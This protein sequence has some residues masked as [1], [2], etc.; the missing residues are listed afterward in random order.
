MVLLIYSLPTALQFVLFALAMA[1]W[2][3]LLVFIGSDE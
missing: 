2:S 1:A 3:L